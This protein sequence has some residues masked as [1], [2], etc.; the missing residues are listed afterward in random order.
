M[1]SDAT[2]SP[3]PLVTILIPHYKTLE[4]TKLCLRSLKLFTDLGKVRVIVI[5]NHS[6]DDSTEYL[7]TLNWITLIIRTPTEAETPSI[8]HARALDVGLAQTRT[9]YILS[10]H[11]DT[12]VTSPQWLDFLL[13]RI[14][15]D[16]GI[17]GVGS[18]KLEHK[19][20]VKRLA[21]TIERWWQQKIWYPLLGKGEGSL[22]GVGRNYYYLRSH[23]ALYKTELVRKYTNGFNDSGETAGKLLHTR[24]LESGYQMVFI[25]SEEL[26]PHVK[27]L[28]HATMI[29]NPEIAGKKTG[30]R[31]ERQRIMRELKS[32]KYEAILGDESLDSP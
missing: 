15:A 19:P 3:Q 32:L 1:T 22:E 14:E 11:T 23:C 2:A 5:D 12:I 6:D 31:K 20:P 4:L 17:A 26:S 27:H 7:K 13:A 18:W 16:P 29:L 10:I 28:N 25:P 21:K 30:S 8:A 9:P 24:L